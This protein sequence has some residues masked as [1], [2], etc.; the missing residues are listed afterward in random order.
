MFPE[1]CSLR[2][3]LSENLHGFNMH[4]HK[5][6]L[7]LEGYDLIA[8]LGR[9]LK[10]FKLQEVEK[11][12]GSWE[13]YAKQTCPYFPKVNLYKNLVAV[14][15]MI[16]TANSSLE[17][18]IP[19]IIDKDVLSWTNNGLVPK[20]RKAGR[21]RVASLSLAPL[22]AKIKILA[23][24]GLQIPEIKNLMFIFG[25]YKNLQKIL[26]S[27][28]N[29]TLEGFS[30]TN[31]K[32]LCV[33]CTLAASYP[34]HDSFI[35]VFDVLKLL[36]EVLPKKPLAISYRD[37]WVWSHEQDCI[38]KAK[39]GKV[40]NYG[41][42]KLIPDY[43]IG[44]SLEFRKEIIGFLVRL[45][46][47]QSHNL[48]LPDLK[49][50]IDREHSTGQQ[51]ALCRDCGKLFDYTILEEQNIVCEQCATEVVYNHCL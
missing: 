22:F 50:A 35:A 23:D 43:F 40:Y 6:R 36:K 31:D 16:S 13:E 33:R 5:R 37:L 19:K 7:L 45:R 21:E 2:K 34:N 12:F 20:M 32:A 28:C 51:I 15:Q 47:L 3:N 8:K 39:N 38:I 42:Q 11:T 30:L 29:S 46:E 44:K 27:K 25:R 18:N 17:N 4:N 41:S 26:C 48:S 10:T 1:F 49:K 24:I 9:P 14:D